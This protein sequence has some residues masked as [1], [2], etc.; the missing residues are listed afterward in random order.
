MSINDSVNSIHSLAQTVSAGTVLF[1]EGTRG[2]GMIILLSGRLNVLKGGH[3]VGT[4]SEAGAYVG[5]AT[6]L[7]G[8]NRSATVVA[9]SSST[10]I[11]LSSIQAEAFLD[12]K[13]AGKKVVRNM[14]E[15]L[16]RAHDQIAGSQ[17]KITGQ[18]DAM[19]ELLGGLRALYDDMKE[20]EATAESMN[21]VRRKVR[22]L[23][24]TYGTGEF[25]K[26][27]IDA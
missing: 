25:S 17:D 11:R 24:N 23:I 14:A 10:I 20:L 7:T 21:E 5:E 27:R 9:D 13:G 15:R 16:E 26:N 12:A 1:E 18:V 8:K 4:I 6:V 19:T 3:K 2:G 22:R